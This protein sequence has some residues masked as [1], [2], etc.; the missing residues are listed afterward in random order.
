MYVEYGRLFSQIDMHRVTS[1]YEERIRDEV[2]NWERNKVLATSETDLVAYL[3]EKY[4]LD[5]PRLFT[6]QKYVE[7]E[8]ETKIDVSQRIE[9]SF[10]PFGPSEVPGHYVIV[11]IPFEGDREIFKFQPSTYGSSP[12]RGCVEGNRVLFTIQDVKL[13]AEQTRREIQAVEEKISM[14]L[15]WIRNDCN[16]WNNRVQSIAEGYLRCRKSR[17]LEQAKMVS[18]LGLPI[19]KRSDPA[20]NILVPLTRKRRLSPLPPTPKE[21]FSPEPAITDLD[22]D[23]ILQTIDLLSQNIERSPSTF[24]NMRE[25]A[26]R[27][28]LLVCLNGQY[29]W[30]ATGE[31]FNGEGK[32]DILIRADG[33]NVFIAECKFWEGSA[34]LH[35]AIDQ[36]LGYLTWRD[37]K[38]ALLVFS[39]RKNFSNVLESA[40]SAVRNHPN[41]KRELRKVG[42]T[43]VRYLFRQK[44]DHDRELYLA[45]Q[46][47]NI[48]SVRS[49][50][51]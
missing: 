9:Y 7:E 33:R 27:D 13:D 30:S 50:A 39:K 1:H 6:G 10:D 51:R 20:P 45:V 36:L 31:T 37:T 34:A 2:E 35:A 17:L 38:S 3:V 22:Y 4:T 23:E 19:R 28:L 11:A 42:E 47:F 43:E 49:V 41:F 21:V 46:L 14:H 15:Q 32:T 24:A 12:L 26:I 44:Y 40:T 29:E 25:E 18:A 8:G 48:P 16:N 5:A